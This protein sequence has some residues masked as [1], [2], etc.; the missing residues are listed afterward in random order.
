MSKLD[1]LG[2]FIKRKV[3]EVLD[4]RQEERARKRRKKAPAKPKAKPDPAPEPKP[5]AKKGMLD[6]FADW[7][8]GEEEEEAEDE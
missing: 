5:A 1:E 2:D 4:E 6:E 8:L 3:A 7:L